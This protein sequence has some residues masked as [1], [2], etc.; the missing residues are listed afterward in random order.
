[1]EQEDKNQLLINVLLEKVK[2]LQEDLEDTQNS[3]AFWIDSYMER[4]NELA[5]LKA[6]TKP[7]R[8]RPVKKRGPGR[9]KKVKK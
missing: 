5:R 7:K 8:G 9:P 2:E 1:M 4:T 6:A 3:R